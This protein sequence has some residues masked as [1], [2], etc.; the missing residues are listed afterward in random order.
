[1]ACMAELLRQEKEEDMTGRYEE[2]E[3]NNE[4]QWRNE[5]IGLHGGRQGIQE[6]KV[7][8]KRRRNLN[9]NSRRMTG[10]IVALTIALIVLGAGIGFLFVRYGEIKQELDKVSSQL[11]KLQEG[12]SGTT[13]EIQ[14]AD[15]AAMVNGSK[16]TDPD[17]M[18]SESM[19]AE[20]DESRVQGGQAESSSI[21]EVRDGRS[22]INDIVQMQSGTNDTVQMQ[23]EINDMSQMQNA[24]GGR[25]ENL[26]TGLSEKVSLDSF[27]L[28]EK[29]AQLFMVTPEALTGV[30]T[31][32]AAGSAT[33]HAINSYPVGGLV[34]FSNNIQSE[35]QF[36][37]MV[38]NV[39]KYSKSRIGL[40]MLIGVDEEGGTVTRIAG[41]GF[42]GVA[43][44]PDMYSI[45]ATYDTEQAYQ[46][47]RDIGSYLSRFQVNVDFA[48]VADVWSNQNNSV[49]GT[50]SFGN[51]AD[52][53]AAMVAAEVKGLQEEGICATL[54]H[55]PG[56]GDTAED[57]HAGTATSWK[58]LEELRS[59]EFLPFEAGIEAG[60]E[61]VM[62]GHISVPNVTGDNLPASLSYMLVTEILR[63]ELG[64]DGVVVTDAMNMG[65][66]TSVY[67]SGEAAVK[68]IQAGVDLILMPEDFYGAYSGVLEAVKNGT[69]SEE[70]LN[71]S[72][73]RI[74]RLKQERYAA[75]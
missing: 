64:F 74:L 30:G 57:S 29:V 56:H 4:R 23:S 54:K 31:V 70:R 32:T 68:A 36:A 13:P 9:R 40:P 18:E 2:Q 63:D 11:E 5:S 16:V 27:T 49:I 58:T 15:A 71:E 10:A 20:G 41:R 51:D 61:L 38:Q 24:M 53:V 75:S 67:G 46:I 72:V 42:A 1:M 52:L 12:R 28:E 59:C 14:T 44:Q 50:R 65:A 43:D 73:E 69:V 21:S 37:Q 45:G 19:S 8:V 6:K 7:P 26:S 47:G 66:I 39:Q 62:A 34:Y 25:K 17:V 60:A 35:E 33:E 22:E 55:F 48:P 3:N